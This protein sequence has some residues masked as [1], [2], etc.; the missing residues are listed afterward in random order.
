MLIFDPERLA[1]WSDGKW[2]GNVPIDITG[3]CIDARKMERQ[4]LTRQF[5]I[6]REACARE[7]AVLERMRDV[8]TQT[9]AKLS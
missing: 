8:L 2:H 7:I 5:D 3:F 4:H 1:Q 6:E 9:N